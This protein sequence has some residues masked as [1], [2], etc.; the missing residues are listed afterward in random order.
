MIRAAATLLL[1]AAAV[2]PSAA[3][4]QSAPITA[5]ADPTRR[6][7][8]YELAKLLNPE[9]PVMAA[10]EAAFGDSLPEMLLADPEMKEMEARYPGIVKAMADAMRP[11]LL[12]YLRESMP[13]LW[14]RM[15]VVYSELSEADLRAVIGF[16]RTPTG[17]RII[18]LMTSDAQLGPMLQELM[19]DEDDTTTGQE[20][21]AA[22][23]QAAT[24]AVGKMTQ[25][26]IAEAARFAATPAG[27]R[28]VALQPRMAAVMADWSNRPSP[29]VQ[30]ELE[31]VLIPV[32]ERF[33]GMKVDP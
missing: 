18:E 22:A 26:Q 17:T 20:L 7:L 29:E 32:V 15:A 3:L 6:A 12:R 25:A 27:R 31:A 30:A 23:R 21:S 11:I 28:A 10:L 4:A 16:Y 5:T 14:D 1:A 2:A 9:A 24:A 19:A 13:E 33:T 8:G